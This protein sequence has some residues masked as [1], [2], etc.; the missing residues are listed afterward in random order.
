M[1][2]LPSTLDPTKSSGIGYGSKNGLRMIYGGES[3]PPN[4]YKI[5]GQFE[6][7]RPNQGK[8]FGLPHSVYQKVYLPG[9]KTTTTTLE[10]PGPG[11]YEIK[12]LV[13]TNPKKFSIH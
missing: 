7:L 13:G 3:P 8:S 4:S 10:A 1:L 11:N 12:G 5:K 6:K 2:S 9:N